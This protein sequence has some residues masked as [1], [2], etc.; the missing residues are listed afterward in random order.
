MI[1]LLYQLSYTAAEPYTRRESSHR[2]PVDVKAPVLTVATGSTYRSDVPP[3]RLDPARPGCRRVR[4]EEEEEMRFAA[5]VP[6]VG[7]VLGG[8]LTFVFCSMAMKAVGRAARK[9]VEEVR[10]QFHSMPGIMEGTTKPDYARCVQI[11]VG[12]AQ[13]EMV[14]PSLIAISLPIV[15]GILLG[16]SGVMGV[17]AGGLS[18]G[19][20]LAVTLNSTG[21][22]W[23]NAKKY[24]EK[25]NLGGKGS[26]P[27]KAAVVGD[28]V[29]DP[30]KD[31]AG[32]CLNI[33]IKLV[34]M[35]AI[36]F[37]GVVVKL[38]PL[39]GQWLHIGR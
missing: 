22:T 25:G 37:A 16:P 7:L 1:H 31:T 39:V 19:F 21:A 27:H 17:L 28:T 11:S 12:A 29:G 26:G 30:F 24:I 8:M 10:R 32:P 15:V 23:D 34:S 3:S 5:W 14:L 36:V 9:M 4:D 13:R 35:V 6:L 38:S 18:T 20:V 2:W 33:I